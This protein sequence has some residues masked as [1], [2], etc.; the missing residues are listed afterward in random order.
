MGILGIKKD[1][2]AE[3]GVFLMWK[4]GLLPTKCHFST[5]KSSTVKTKTEK[6]GISFCSLSP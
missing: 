6:G 3:F 1:T 2:K 5:P 4:I